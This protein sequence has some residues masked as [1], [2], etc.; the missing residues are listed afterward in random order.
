MTHVP[1]AHPQQFMAGPL[2]TSAMTDRANRRTPNTS[3]STPRI[4]VAVVDTG[5]LITAAEPGLAAFSR[6]VS[7]KNGSR[8]GVQPLPKQRPQLIQGDRYSEIGAKWGASRSRVFGIHSVTAKAI[9]ANMA[10]TAYTIPKLQPRWVVAPLLAALV[11]AAAPCCMGCVA[12]IVVA[13]PVL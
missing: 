4:S 11:R 13:V 9:A 5:K 7:A 2:V 6:G 3:A 10:A 1:K 8:D 12:G